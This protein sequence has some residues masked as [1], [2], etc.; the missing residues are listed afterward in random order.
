MQITLLK[1]VVQKITRD[2]QANL[3]IVNLERGAKGNTQEI[4][5]LMSA[6]AIKVYVWNGENHYPISF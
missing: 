5:K 1:I 3:R 6:S 4:V 2:S